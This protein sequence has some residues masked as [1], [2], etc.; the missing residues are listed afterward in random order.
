MIPQKSHQARTPMKIKM[1]IF[2]LF[3]MLAGH[4]ISP[5]A[6]QNSTSTKSK[7]LVASSFAVA[8]ELL[9][10]TLIMPW[11]VNSNRLNKI[12]DTAIMCSACNQYQ[13]GFF[14]TYG[15]L[16]IK[17]DATALQQLKKFLYTGSGKELCNFLVQI[18]NQYDTKCVHCQTAGNWHAML[19]KGTP[20]QTT[21]TPA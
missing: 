17:N 11:F 15:I 16:T 19:G 18:N 9:Y 8:K 14:Y 21:P 13:I 12:C 20:E 1:N 2:L 5:T 4:T 10:I 6:A 3:C 7:R